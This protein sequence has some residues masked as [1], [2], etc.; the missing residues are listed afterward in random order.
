MQG[1]VISIPFIRRIALTYKN[2]VEKL[3]L[4]LYDL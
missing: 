2:T 1:C 4:I 3:M